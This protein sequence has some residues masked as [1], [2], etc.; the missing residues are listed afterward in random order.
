MKGGKLKIDN[1]VIYGEGHRDVNP[2]SLF[3]E[4]LQWNKEKHKGHVKSHLHSSLFQISIIDRGM[5]YFKSDTIQKII[6]EPTIILIPEDHLHSFKFEQ[7][8]EGWTVILSQKILDELFEKYPS[9]FPNFSTVRL[10]ENL[11][12]NDLYKSIIDLCEQIQTEKNDNG[13]N[14]WIFNHSIVGLIFYYI[15]KICEQEGADSYYK[16]ESK[17]YIHLRKFKKL[18]REKIDAR[19]KVKDYASQL[20][21]TTTHLNRLCNSLTGVSASQTI[22]NNVILESKKYLKYSTFSV[23][24]IAYIINFKTPSHFSNFFKSQ[25]GVSPKY[26]REKGGKNQ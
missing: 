21:I 4:P 19:V 16:K 10:I 22:Y 15:N 20:N 2:Y 3:V 9:A 14:Q 18:I 12:N 26:Y 17:E 11:G 6:S 24:E 8:T 7:P 1:L 25:T 5:I 13:L 23:S